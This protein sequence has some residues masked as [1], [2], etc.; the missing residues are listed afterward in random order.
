MSHLQIFILN[1]LPFLSSKRMLKTAYKVI[2]VTYKAYFLYPNITIHM[3]I[4]MDWMFM[5]L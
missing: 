4:I 5:S 3:Y 2:F 1:L